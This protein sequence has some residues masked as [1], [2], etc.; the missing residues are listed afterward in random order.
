MINPF[1]KTWYVII[2]LLKTLIIF[3]N[4]L[5]KNNKSK[6]LNI[7]EIK[8]ILL[9]KRINKIWNQFFLKQKKNITNKNVGGVNISDQKLFFF[10]ISY[11]KP[12]NILEIGTHLGNSL[13]SLAGS[14]KSNKLFNSTID[15]VDIYDVNKSNKYIKFKEKNSPIRLLQK[16]NISNLVNFY[17]DGSDA[18]FKKNNKKYDLIFID[19]NHTIDQA[20]KDIANAFNCL[21]KNGI[22][23]IHDYYD[24]E[25]LSDLFTK[26]FGPF[27]AIYFLKKKMKKLKVVKIFKLG[28]LIRVKTTLAILN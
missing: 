11:F 17:K 25:S 27:L 8:R 3:N 20:F 1:R 15:T 24:I 2:Q 18:F 9:N 10:I 19:G 14:L 26:I 13:N 28:N 23:I 7:T 12:K 6:Q 4:Y 16:N 5:I 22:I 21:N